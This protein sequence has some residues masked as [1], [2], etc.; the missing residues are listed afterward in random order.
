MLGPLWVAPLVEVHADRVHLVDRAVEAG[1]EVAV[2]AQGLAD[3]PRPA[4]LRLELDRLE[5]VDVGPVEELC[6][7]GRLGSLGQTAQVKLDSP[8]TGWWR[9]SCGP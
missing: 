2:R 9:S 3:E 8:G 5:V 6:D 7:R 4:L 1:L